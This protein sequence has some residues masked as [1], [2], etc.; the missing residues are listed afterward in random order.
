M[1]DEAPV[2]T[3]E[4]EPVSNQPEE[5]LP[6]EQEQVSDPPSEGADAEAGPVTDE[7]TEAVE[8]YS[9]ITT[10]LA[11]LSV[12][13]SAAEVASAQERLVEELPGLWVAPD[14]RE[15]RDIG[16]ASFG[17]P[18]MIEAVIGTDDRIQIT[19]TGVYPW[20]VHASL[21]ITAADNSQ[22]IGTGWFIGPHTL[23]TAGHVV[24]IKNS[25][26][27]GRDGW[28]K[29]IS[30]MPGRNGNT[31]PYGSVISTNFRTVAGWANS[32]DQNYDYGAI[33]IPS[34]LGGT[35]GWF[36]FGAWSDADLVASWANISGYPGDKPAGTQW[37]HSRKVVSVGPRKVY[38]DID[39]AGGQSGSAVYRI[40]AGG[41]Y[42]MAIHAY[43]GTTTNSGTRIT[44]PVFNNLVNW[45]A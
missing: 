43:G 5:V 37:Y 3:G 32:G 9:P 6:E 13:A 17:R 42:G 29:S 28:V 12:G 44:T 14:T 7:G 30:V 45:K 41:R 23:A 25:G 22:W 2:P 10:E 19:N 34:E 26:V 35:T 21:L 8:G 11:T 15:L 40:I 18:P 39:T 38:Y 36:G 1:A 24:Y 20:R 16:E 4:H 33:I 31:L 27:Q